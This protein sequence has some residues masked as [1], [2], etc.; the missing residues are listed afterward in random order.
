MIDD[1]EEVQM[2]Y[3]RKE[4]HFAKD[5]KILMIA[6]FY[7]IIHKEKVILPSSIGSVMVQ[8]THV[9]ETI[10]IAIEEDYEIDSEEEDNQSSHYA[11]MF[12]PRPPTKIAEMVQVHVGSWNP[13]QRI[14]SQKILTTDISRLN[15]P[16]CQLTTCA[17]CA[18]NY[19][20]KTVNVKRKQPK[21]SEEESDFSNNEVKLLKELLKEKTKQ[22]QQMIRDQAKEYYENKAAMQKKEE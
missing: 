15:C 14:T 9:E 5:C 7:S 17:L 18:R 19:L 6:V 10:F 4:G 2:L 3:L 11:F 12:H 20:G 13:K 22:V 21:K 8:D 16:K 1:S